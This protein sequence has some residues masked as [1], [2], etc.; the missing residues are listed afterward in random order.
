[1]I[2]APASKARQAYCAISSGVP[3]NWMA[4]FTNCGMPQF[5]LATRIAEGS[6]AEARLTMDAMSSEGPTPQLLPHAGPAPPRQ[7]ARGELG[8]ELR[9]MAEDGGSATERGPK[10]GLADSL[11][12]PPKGACRV[13]GIEASLAA[14]KVQ[15]K[16]NHKAFDPLSNF[17]YIEGGLGRLPIPTGRQVRR[18]EFSPRKRSGARL[19]KGAADSFVCKCSVGSSMAKTKGFIAV[20]KGALLLP[21]ASGVEGRHFAV[22]F[23]IRMC[24]KLL[25]VEGSVQ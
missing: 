22:E 1:M 7:S 19:G 15:P 17:S 2:R 23:A 20:A 8:P 11:P 14:T 13:V 25:R 10:K 6:E 12:L 9:K 4:P 5:A 3:L 16:C 18:T 21:G 24:S